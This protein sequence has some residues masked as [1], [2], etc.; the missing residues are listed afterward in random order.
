MTNFSFELKSK[1]WLRCVN[2][3]HT[4]PYRAA[5]LER[6]FAGL[7]RM[8]APVTADDLDALLTTGEWHKDKP[9]LIPAFF[10]GYRDNYDVAYRL[11]ERYNMVGCFFVVTGFGALKPEEQ[12]DFAQHPRFHPSRDPYPDQRLGLDWDEIREMSKRH[13]ICSHTASHSIALDE[14]TPPA[15]LT[16]EIIGSSRAIAAEVGYTPPAFCWL[17]GEPY[18]NCSATHTYLRAANYRFIFGSRRIEKLPR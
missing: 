7:A 5:E 13:V 9:G 17:Y 18:E 14:T 1:P 4:P 16:R 8:F 15:V 11:L 10:N 6:L 12:L 3:H 2:F